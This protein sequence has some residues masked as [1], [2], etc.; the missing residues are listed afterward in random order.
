[1]TVSAVSGFGFVDTTHTTLAILTFSN[2]EFV[3]VGTVCDYS[4][5]VEIKSLSLYEPT[6][7]LVNLE[8]S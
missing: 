8:R 6:P 2:C 4:V 3:D 7:A 5:V 1:M